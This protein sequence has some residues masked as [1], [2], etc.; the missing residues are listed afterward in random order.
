MIAVSQDVSNDKSK[1]GYPRDRSICLQSLLSTSHLHGLESNRCSP[2]EMEKP[3]F[4]ICFPS[5]LTDR[6]SSLKSQGRGI[7][8]DFG[9]SKL[10]CTTLVQ[11]NSR[12]VH[13]RTSTPAPVS[14]TFGR[15][16][17][18]ST[19]SSIKQDFKTN[20]LKTFRKNLAE[21]GIS[22]TAA[23]LI[24]DSRRSGTTANYQSAWKKWV[25]WCSKKQID[26]V[27]CSINLFENFSLP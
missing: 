4:S 3:R 13:K 24:S 19:F 1:L 9:N 23:N 18:T 11:S 25:S 7:N 17:G 20:G 5:F 27:T 12:S 22:N 21:K 15:S 26:P 16:Q 10:A 6:K 14:G 2:T 8:N